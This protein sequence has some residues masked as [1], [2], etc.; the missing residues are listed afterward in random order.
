MSRRLSPSEQTEALHALPGWSLTA[1]GHALTRHMVFR[2]FSEAFAFMTRI[3]LAAEKADH[4]PEWHNVYNR[5]TLTLS[6]HDAGG[7]TQKDIDLAQVINGL[8]VPPN[9]L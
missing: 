2:D 6:T 3:A 8:G 5:L 9:P 7:I 4:H 1:E